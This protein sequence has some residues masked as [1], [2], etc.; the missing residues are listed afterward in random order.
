MEWS[1]Q[2]TEKSE[3]E[4]FSTTA[5]WNALK[6]YIY[7]SGSVILLV[8]AG[9]DR[10]DKIDVNDVNTRVDLTRTGKLKSIT[11]VLRI[12]PLVSYGVCIVSRL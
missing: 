9:T 4:S 6:F 3:S 7:A 10:V 12:I 1:E 5:K 2:N 11:A 8:S